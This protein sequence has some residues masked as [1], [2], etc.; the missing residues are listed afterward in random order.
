MV[1]HVKTKEIMRVGQ[2][3]PVR[4]KLACRHVAAAYAGSV[5][6]AGM[7]LGKVVGKRAEA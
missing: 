3:R 1:G 4:S 6:A 5:A 7:R 2:E